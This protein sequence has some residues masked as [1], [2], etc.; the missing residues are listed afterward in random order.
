[1]KDYIYPVCH[2]SYFKE[3]NIKTVDDLKN[4]RLLDDKVSNISWDYW[5][6]KKGLSAHFGHTDSHI[7]KSYSRVRYDGS[8]YVV[9]SALS[10]QGVAMARHSLVSESIGQAQLVRLLDEPVELAAQFYLC[11]PQHHFEFTKI[12]LFS[13][14]LT[15]EVNDF[16]ERNPI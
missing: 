4:L 1:M 9:D 12:M 14:W 16:C 2:P 11:A 7:D 6:E 13:N 8:H 3:H 10:A 5:F 15:K